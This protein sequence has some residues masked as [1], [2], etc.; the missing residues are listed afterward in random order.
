[1]WK[2]EKFPMQ[3]QQQGCT[4][5]LA[6]YW[7]DANQNTGKLYYK[8]LLMPNDHSLL[9]NV[10]I[11]IG[12]FIGIQTFNATWGLIVTWEDVQLNDDQVNIQL[13]VDNHIVY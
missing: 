3:Q 11:Q 9:Q 12:E 6:V 7:N 5:V 2:T 8:I 13:N 4:S 10:S 1:M